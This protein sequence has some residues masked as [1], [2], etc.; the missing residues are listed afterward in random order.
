MSFIAF[1]RFLA[2]FRNYQRKTNGKFR[3]REPRGIPSRRNFRSVC[4]RGPFEILAA[5][6]PEK[7]GNRCGILLHVLGVSLVDSRT[8]LFRDIHDRRQR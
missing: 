7:V 1:S 8:Q 3:I 4:V 5:G 2:V 6:L